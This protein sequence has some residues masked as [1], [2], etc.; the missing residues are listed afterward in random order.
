V[1]VFEEERELAV[2]LLV[3]VSNSTGFGTLRQLKHDVIT[4]ISAVLAYSALKNNDK[5]GVIFFSDKIERFI[6]PLKGSSHILRI[7][8][9]LVDVEPVA[10]GTDLNAALEF[11]N[12]VMKKKSVVF[13]LSD[14]IT[15]D[16]ETMLRITARK[17][18]LIGIHVFDKREIGNPRQRS[19]YM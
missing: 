3:D 13:V 7:I 10:A 14:F 18:D 5:T 1:K 19:C 2:M 16:Y 12:N 11:L 4:E 6:P 17:H 8:R 15:K 9:E